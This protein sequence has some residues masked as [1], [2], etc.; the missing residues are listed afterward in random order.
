MST[1]ALPPSLIYLLGSPGVGKRTVAEALAVQTGAAVI[2]NH[3]INLPVMSMFRWDGRATLPRE[4]W[5]YVDRI[6][7]AVLDALAEIAPRGASYVLTNALEVGY[8]PWFERIEEIARQR[9]ALFAP[10]LLECDLEEQLRRVASDDRRERLKL[11]DPD[12]AREFI[13]GTRFFVPTGPTALV[14]DTTRRSPADT[15]AL[16]AEH[17]RSLVGDA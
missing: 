13:A 3:Q 12:R 17:V 11:S 5:G 15:A 10:V 4:V 14:L 8:E 2:D 9:G 1:Q 7:S 6:R 16:V